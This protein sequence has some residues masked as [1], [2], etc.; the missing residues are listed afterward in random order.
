MQTGKRRRWWA[1]RR[2]EAEP[3]LRP[4]RAASRR[5]GR[6]KQRRRRRRGGDSKCGPAVGRGSGPRPALQALGRPLGSRSRR[7]PAAALLGGSAGASGPRP[8]SWRL[9][10]WP[11]PQR[12]SASSPPSLLLPLLSS[13]FPSFWVSTF[14]PRF[15]AL[16]PMDFLRLDLTA[17][18]WGAWVWTGQPRVSRRWLTVQTGKPEAGGVHNPQADSAMASGW[19]REFPSSAFP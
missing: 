12:P 9:S 10:L 3:G 11:P 15:S 16:L 14:S 19:H 2:L 1:G 4:S 7:P 8:L 17:W 18:I 5:S 6:G 13:H